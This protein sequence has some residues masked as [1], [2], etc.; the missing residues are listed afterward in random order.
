MQKKGHQCRVLLPHLAV[1]LLPRGQLGKSG[2]Q[3]LLRIALKAPLTANSVRFLS[4][5]THRRRTRL[6]LTQPPNSHLGRLSV[7][8]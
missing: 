7:S 5:A 4:N 1:E 2:P 3:V 8:R 6:T